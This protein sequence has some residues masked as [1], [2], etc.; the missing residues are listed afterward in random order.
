MPNPFIDEEAF[1]GWKN[2]PDHK[3]DQRIMLDWREWLK[4]RWAGGSASEADKA[5][6]I[7][8]GV[9]ANITWEEICDLYSIGKEEIS[10]VEG[11]VA[12]GP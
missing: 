6:A 11:T 4:E 1:T 3:I 9:M 2:S 5:F 8:L 12:T 7:A 10:D